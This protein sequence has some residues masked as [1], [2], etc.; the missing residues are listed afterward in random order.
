MAEKASKKDM[1]EQY[2]AREM[3]GG[4]YAVKNTAKNKLL[5]DAAVDLRGSK[6]RFD[7]AAKTGSCV[8]P[9]LQKDWNE[10][11][12]DQFVFEILEEITKGDTQS[13]AD[14]KA[15]VELMKQMWIEKLAGEDFY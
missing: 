6:S 14:F 4:V 13:P 5:V 11:G 1:Q 3:V 9:K 10:Q 15:D 2:K 12:G 8:Y 7:F